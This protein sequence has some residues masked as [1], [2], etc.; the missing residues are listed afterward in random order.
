MEGE[1]GP[2]SKV[3]EG[4]KLL[5]AKYK[6][7]NFYVKAK[8]VSRGPATSSYLTFYTSTSCA[9]VIAVLSCHN[10]VVIICNNSVV[11]LLQDTNNWRQT[12]IHHILIK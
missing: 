8:V 10:F 4:N 9:F 2:A 7:K 11:I 3:L 12:N 5:K 6:I 1:R